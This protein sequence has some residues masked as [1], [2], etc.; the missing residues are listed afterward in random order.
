MRGKRKLAAY[1]SDLIIFQNHD[2]ARRSIDLGLVQQDKFQVILGSGVETDTFD[3]KRVSDNERAHV[4]TDLEIGPDD[5]VV[6]MVSRVIKSQG[7]LEFA[8]SARQLRTR[9]PEVRFLLVGP[10]DDVDL[11]QLSP[12]ELRELKDSVSWLGP[13]RD[14]RAVLSICD[15]LALPTAYGEGIP[16]VLLEGASMGLPIVAI[17]TAGCNEVVVDGFNG[18]LVPPRD[19]ERLTRALLRLIEEAHLREQFGRRSRRRA[20]TCFDISI[21]ADQTRSV[22]EQ[23]LRSKHLPMRAYS[24]QESI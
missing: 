20:I 12:I 11:D 19:P 10:T 7:V 13:R 23:L 22:Y 15:I 21:V 18:I 9:Y 16:R 6:A 1:A 4:R 3:Q 24:G 14:I 5:V 8:Q 17:D 2:D